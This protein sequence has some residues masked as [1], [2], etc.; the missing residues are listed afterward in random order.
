M[1][2][3][4]DKNI[5]STSQTIEFMAQF[6]FQDHSETR[7]YYTLEGMIRDSQKEKKRKLKSKRAWRTRY[8]N[9]LTEHGKEFYK[10]KFGT[11]NPFSLSENLG[12]TMNEWLSI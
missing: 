9:V 2:T 10:A 4:H 12:L 11:L 1:K 7:F 6:D 3:Y 5:Y 8:Q